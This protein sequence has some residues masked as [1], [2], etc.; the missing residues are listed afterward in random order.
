MISIRLTFQLNPRLW[1]FQKT[2]I[3]NILTLNIG[4]FGLWYVNYSKKTFNYK[5]LIICSGAPG[6]GKSTMVNTIADNYRL[7]TSTCAAH[8]V[9]I[10]S[11][12]SYFMVD[13][14]YK[15]DPSKLGHNHAQNQQRVKN[16]LKEEC[17]IIIVDNTNTTFKEQDP[18]VSA[19]IE[20]GYEVEFMTPY[21]SWSHDAEECFKR[22]THG[23]PLE[24]IKNMLDRLVTPEESVAHFTKKYRKYLPELKAFTENSYKRGNY[25]I[26][27]K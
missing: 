19:A 1:H 14:E 3:G 17:E 5:K 11:T 4:P 23:V 16:L 20:A 26:Q 12:D 8:E 9:E 27:A 2:N 13:G 18:Y 10:C 24:T 15:F 7:Q 22:N 25:G 6:S 21:N